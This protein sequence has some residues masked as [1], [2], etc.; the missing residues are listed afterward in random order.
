[1]G[2]D[3][4]TQGQDILQE[5]FNLIVAFLILE[6][7][8]LLPRWLWFERWLDHVSVQATLVRRTRAHTSFGGRIRAFLQ[9][10]K[11]VA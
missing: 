2:F 4:L 10:H 7:L 9:Y 6:R 8:G 11:R 5:T 1:M 3:N